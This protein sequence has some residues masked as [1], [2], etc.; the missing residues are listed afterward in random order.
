MTRRIA[1]RRLAAATMIV[2]G[3]SA[4][5]REPPAAPT[6]LGAASNFSQGWNAD[7]GQAALDL[8]L[9][10]LRDSIRWE[11]VE[12]T[13]GVYSFDKPTTTWPDRF[14]QSGA[15]IT[16]TLNWGNPLYDNGET[17][18][19]PEALAAFGR[20]AAAVVQ[21]FPQIDT[22][23]IGN[24]I[25]SANFVS[26]MVKDAGIDERGRYHL[27]MVQAAAEAVHAVRPGVIVLGGSA[28]SLPA[29]FLWP[30]LD[31]P[32]AGAIQGLAV[33]PYTTPIDQ[34]PAQVAFL[35][36]HGPAARLPLYVTEFGSQ[37][38]Q[39]AADDLVRSYATLATLGT[40]EADWYPFNERGDGLIPLVARDGS[41]TNAGKAFRF[42]QARLSGRVGRD[43]SPDRFTFVRAFGNDVQVVWGAP[44][45]L[46]VD[47]GKIT[48]YD[49]TGA[50]LDTRPLALAEDR[51]LVLV[52]SQPLD[53]GQFITWGC[54]TLVADSFY[55]F[56]YPPDGP[57][58]APRDGFQR[59]V[60]SGGRELPFEAMP[61]QQRP[62]V[63][64]TPYLGLSDTGSVRLMADTMLPATGPNGGIIHR[65]VA[66]REGRVHLLA[67]FAP[68]ADSADGITVAAALDGKALLSRS[69][70]APITIDL[71]V[72]MRK[73]QPLTLTVGPGASTRGD[74]T[75]YRIRIVDEERCAKAALLH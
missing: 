16:L 11:D 29:G 74:T 31:L 5:S 10:R 12:R 72:P 66:T 64:W 25:N 17:P 45:P 75:R 20:F 24:E 7:T 49:A 33:H 37:D 4:Q 3:C 68:S 42:V 55:Q 2:A 73:G 38:P 1:L 50:R 34:L 35:R 69:G 44:R 9:P 71:Q 41:V 27:A 58:Q 60:L 40:A 28:H 51:A 48:A 47:P 13:R 57:S 63:P 21:H 15:R 70:S 30:L 67:D 36:L 62:G 59:F 8:P 18:H 6:R 19:S 39:R 26:G 52:S 46:T 61:G 65:Y 54:Q 23:E 56:G 53:A 14:A 32:G 22:L 43:A